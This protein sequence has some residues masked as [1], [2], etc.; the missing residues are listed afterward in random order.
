MT[1]GGY[2]GWVA[3]FCSFYHH[4]FVSSAVYAL[5]VFYGEW[6]EEFVTGRGLT[7]WILTLSISMSMGT[8]K[9]EEKHVERGGSLDKKK[10][11]KVYMWNGEE[12]EVQEDENEDDEED[13]HHDHT[14][15][16]RENKN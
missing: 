11:R 15:K 14:K 13:D 9:E 5:S 4:A 10:E 8:G 3:V 12:I 6:V 2:Y 16:R 7:S 1:E